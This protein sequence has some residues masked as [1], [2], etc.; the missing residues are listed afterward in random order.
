MLKGDKDFRIEVA[1]AFKIG[2]GHFLAIVG[3]FVIIP[4]ALAALA[5]L[6]VFSSNLDK[7]DKETEMHCI[8]HILDLTTMS[9]QLKTLS[10]TK[11]LAL[12]YG[13]LLGALF[14]MRFSGWFNLRQSDWNQ[15]SLLPTISRFCI[16][17]VWLTLSIWFNSFIQEKVG[18]LMFVNQIGLFL[19]SFG[20]FGFS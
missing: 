16:V 11:I 1:S 14:N 20:L 19:L 5:S 13:S 10:N 15:T 4:M 9:I 2:F 6:R 17:L 18:H 7:L 12:C 3:L 8:D